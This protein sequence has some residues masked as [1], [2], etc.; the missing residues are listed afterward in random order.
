MNWWIGRLA[1]VDEKY[2]NLARMLGDPEVISDMNKLR[3]YSKEH[4]DLT[5]VIEAYREYVSLKDQL[6]EA[7]EMIQEEKDPELVSL[8]R[9]E[10]NDLTKGM[11][12]LEDKLKML[13]LPVDPNDER[14]VLLEV[15][16]G[17]GGDEASLFVADLA[18]MYNRFA[19]RRNWKIEVLNSSP[20]ELGGFREIILLLKGQK[21]YSL[22]KYEGGI[23]RVQRVPETESSGR[24]HTSAVSVVVMPEAEEVEVHINPEDVRVDVFRAS[25]CGGQHVNTTD[26]AVRLTHIPTGLVVSCQDEKSQHKNKSKAMKILQARLLAKEEEERRAEVDGVRRSMV[27]SGDRS[28]R[29]R[30]Y[31]FPQARVSDHRINLTLYKLEA[32]MDGDLDELTQ[33]LMA[34]DQAEQLRS[35]EV[36]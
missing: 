31:N 36:A 7:E 3:I 9:E 28:E 30:T 6:E 8:A 18:R 20:T 19:E 22:L 27:G 16:A 24:I 14:N 25:G 10:K 33:A 34:S 32:V 11:D 23:H 15:R 35:M 5:P 12:E 4:S 29:I 17:T 26:S 21:V 1:Q 13:L 2:E